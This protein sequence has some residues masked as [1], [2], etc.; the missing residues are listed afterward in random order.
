MRPGTFSLVR[1]SYEQPTDPS[2][3]IGFL[4]CASTLGDATRGYD[5]HLCASEPLDNTR[6]AFPR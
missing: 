2:S 3:E 4:F 1:G 6:V 5:E